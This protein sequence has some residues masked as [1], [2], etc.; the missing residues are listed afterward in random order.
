MRIGMVCY[1][2]YGGSGAVAA[3]LGRHLARRGHVVH[4]ITYEVPFRLARFEEGLF[5]HEV[6]V[7]P[8]PLFKYPPYL[9]AL[10]N[11]MVE[12]TRAEHLDILHVHYAIPH[13]A[14]AHL[15]RE[16]LA[17]EGERPPAVVTTLHG[18]DITLV[19][20]D[21]S[22]MA[23]T[24]FMIERS[25]AVTAV[26]D[27]LKRQTVETFGVRNEIVTIP[28]FV[29][30]ADYG[31]E[32]GR[33]APDHTVAPLRR[34]VGDRSEVVVAHISNFRP[35]KRPDVVVKV[36]AAASAG[37]RSRLVL[38]GEGPELPR[39]RELAMR[40]G[41]AQQVVCLGRQER[42]EELLAAC[43][44]FIL[45]SRLEAFGLAALEAMAAG[46]PVVATRVGGLPEVV[47]EGEAGLLY[48][49]DDLEGMAEGLRRLMTDT[50][51]RLDFSRRARDRAFRLFS[52]DRIIPQYE[53]LYERLCAGA[54]AE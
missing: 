23:M 48:E 7:P 5:F 28:N 22:F 27:A 3:E 45:P 6:E 24:K 19:G 54:R 33:E 26:S 29:D 10:A 25:D 16:M 9:L 8:Y 18:T 30:P 39:V 37:V 47:G 20:S 17:M 32:P 34:F 2:S 21:P 49:P 36:F 41:V 31:G 13:A 50:G 15:A 4:F 1:P 43:D 44:L 52:T 11:K 14:S 46:V 12:V 35:I 38:I 53:A 40:L 42:V 51:L